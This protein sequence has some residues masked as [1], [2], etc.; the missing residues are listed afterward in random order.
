MERFWFEA[1]TV[2]NFSLYDEDGVGA[3]DAVVSSAAPST[4]TGGVDV[5]AGGSA[6]GGGGGG[7]G[8]G[9]DVL[10]PMRAIRGSAAILSG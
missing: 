4:A 7:G 9:V 6:G 5:E 8:F 3:D 10:E 2:Q 1:H